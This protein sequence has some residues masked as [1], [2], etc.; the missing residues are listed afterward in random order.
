MYNKKLI[1]F[2]AIF[3]CNISYGM[4]EGEITPL[5]QQIARYNV[6][7]DNDMLETSLNKK[8]LSAQWT[9][10]KKCLYSALTGVG[11][12]AVGSVL[13]K[14][15]G[16]KL[17]G[18]GVATFALTGSLAMVTMYDEKIKRELYTQDKTKLS[19]SI[20]KLKEVLQEIK[21]QAD[22]TGTFEQ[23]T[24]MTT[25]STT[26][27]RND[28]NVELIKTC[29]KDYTRTIDDIKEFITQYSPSKICFYT[30]LAGVFLCAL[31]CLGNENNGPQA[32]KMGFILFLGAG[33]IGLISGHNE[34]QNLKDFILTKIKA[35]E[36]IMNIN[37]S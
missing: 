27:H 29:N 14:E 35:R 34:Q 19:D 31:A 10:S 22:T 9:D 1:F 13:P 26:K 16:S 37:R 6:L 32:A 20:K 7:L 25:T 23:S 18:M 15:I 11:I 17:L 21:H 5:N 33:F 24:K 4:D 12:C 28:I 2:I 30:S 36:S 3:L 8:T